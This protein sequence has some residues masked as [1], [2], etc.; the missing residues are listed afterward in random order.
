MNHLLFDDARI[1]AVA[2]RLGAFLA[3]FPDKRFTP[4]P[5]GLLRAGVALRQA[6]LQDVKTT[7]EGKPIGIE[8]LP[9]GGLK[10]QGPN[11]EMP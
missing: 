11:H 10:H 7:G 6:T 2:T 8:L 1:D 5:K 9:L 3:E 4:L